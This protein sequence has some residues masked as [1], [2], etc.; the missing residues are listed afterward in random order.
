MQQILEVRSVAPNRFLYALKLVLSAPPS[1]KFGMVVV[2]I[3]AF[4]ALFAPLLAPYGEV[5]VASRIPFEPW[6]AN[7][8]L[9]TDQLGRDFLS[10]LIFGARNSI[11]VALVTT[12]ISFVIGC[13]V[14]IFA[15]LVGGF[16]DQVISRLVDALMSIWTLS[17]R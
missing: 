10:R 7:H 12:A 15:A 17:S 11:S 3:Y 14:G 6:S 4:V 2:A 1:A 8:L 13:L 5:E 16:V 9:G